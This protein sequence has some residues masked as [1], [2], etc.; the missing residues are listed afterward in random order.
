MNSTLFTSASDLS[1]REQEYLSLAIQ[2]MPDKIIADIMGLSIHTVAKHRKNI[3]DKLNTKSKLGSV[4]E[5]LRTN[6]INL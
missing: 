6:I 4:V 3:Q 5:A 1:D 2:D